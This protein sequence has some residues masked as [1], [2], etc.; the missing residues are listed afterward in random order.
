MCSDA[1]LPKGREEGMCIILLP[2]ALKF[3][4]ANQSWYICFSSVALC[5]LLTRG[6]SHIFTHTDSVNG[7]LRCV[8]EVCFRKCLL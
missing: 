7:N 5:F 8:S 6:S 3:L 1:E 2:V 4:I